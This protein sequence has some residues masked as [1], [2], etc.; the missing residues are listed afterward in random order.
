MP[1]AISSRIKTAAD[2][3]RDGITKAIAE[4][5]NVM[6]G[7]VEIDDEGSVHAGSWLDQDQMDHMETWLDQNYP[8][9]D[10]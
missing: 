3:D 2:N 5:S 9:W 4:Q 6:A 7:D 10:K 1:A 8:G